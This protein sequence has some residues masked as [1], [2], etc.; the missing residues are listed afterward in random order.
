MPSH[1]ETRI[2]PYSAEEMFAIVADIER[3]PEFV[4]GCVALRILDR[5]KVGVV[6]KLAAEMRV[7]VQAL[8]EKYTS[9]VALDP[10]ARTIE[11]HHIEGPFHHLDTIW[12]FVPRAEGCEVHFA[13]DF[14]FKNPVLSAFAGLVFEKITRKMTDAFVARA[15]AVYG[16][17]QDVEQ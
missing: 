14:A 3:Y 8:R 7:S 2:L 12:R 1:S 17:S 11:A 6:E 15:R 5:E 10:N 4:P 16:T 13:V 9:L